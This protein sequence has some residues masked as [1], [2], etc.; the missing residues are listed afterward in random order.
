MLSNIL[1]G[2]SLQQPCLNSYHNNRRQPRSR[3]SFTRLFKN[4]ASG[5]A[6]SN[7]YFHL[8]A[9]MFFVSLRNKPI[10][11][12]QQADSVTDCVIVIFKE[13]KISH[14]GEQVFKKTSLKLCAS[15]SYLHFKFKVCTYN[16]AV[17]TT[18]AS[19][20]DVLVFLCSPYDC[21]GFHPQEA[22][23]DSKL[24]VGMNV[25]TNGCLCLCVRPVRDR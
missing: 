8:H 5:P 12:G 4:T 16:H 21:V 15:Y 10:T 13:H 11:R 2:T 14:D 23:A 18:L 20:K 22:T 19:Q 9:D 24:A 17:V 3:K 25:S 6:H 1:P 7:N